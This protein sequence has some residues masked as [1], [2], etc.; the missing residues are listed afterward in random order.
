MQVGRT[1]RE[2][3]GF[4]LVVCSALLVTLASCQ[5]KDGQHGVSSSARREVEVGVQ[6]KQEAPLSQS[7]EEES[8]SYLSEPSI[9]YVKGKT[10]LRLSAIPR[11]GETAVVTFSITPEEEVPLM[12]VSFSLKGV[13][14]VS[15]DVTPMGPGLFKSY[16][17]AEANTKRDVTICV[18]FVENSVNVGAGAAKILNKT[19]PDEP[20]HE[21]IRIIGMKGFHYD[22]DEDLHAY[23]TWEEFTSKPWWRF[24][25]LTGRMGEMVAPTILK[26]NQEWIGRMQRVRADMTVWEVLFLFYDVLNTP[27]SPKKGERC[28]SN[29]ERARKLLDT[30]WLDEF[31]GT[32]GQSLL[33]KYPALHL[34]PEAT[35]TRPKS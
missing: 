20:G 18:R 11:R 16:T 5:Q 1:L 23:V 28:L 14:L 26:M 19:H 29:E 30:G 6:E 12:R 9:P 31:R 32:G 24:D 8:P 35:G 7:K 13:E 34:P 4:I 27:Y 10:E 21:V 22:Y 17:S 15:G 33:K 25:P 3:V 2:N